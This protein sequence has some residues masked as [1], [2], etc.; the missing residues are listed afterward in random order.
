MQRVNYFWHRF[1]K[2]LGIGRCTRPIART[3]KG[4]LWQAIFDTLELR[5]LYNVAPVGDVLMTYD[6]SSFST[7][8]LGHGNL[9]LD[10]P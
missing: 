7:K 4:M 8:R 5:Q 2:T 9:K 3:R 6:T 1:R 10:E